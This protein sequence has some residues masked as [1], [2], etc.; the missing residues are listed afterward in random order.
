MAFFDFLTGS[1]GKIRQAPLYNQNQLQA[2]QQLLNRGMQQSD[3]GA[4]TNAA[5]T[6]FYSNTVPSLAERFT[7]M[8]GFGDG[9][10]R[11]SGFQ[12][13]LSSG[14]VGL[15][16]GLAQMGAQQGMNFLNMGLGRQYENNYFG[17]TPG[18]LQQG[19]GYGL[20]GLMRMLPFLN[21]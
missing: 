9:A 5:K 14:G 18:L 1:S 21:L 7:S 2:M 3:I 6:N 12:Q 20:Y 4:L 17:G 8:G 15:D 16:E 19:A 13:A 11:S 10:Q